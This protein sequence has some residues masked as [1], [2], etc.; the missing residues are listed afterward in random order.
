MVLLISASQVA[1]ITG[2]TGTWQLFMD[3]T[4]VFFIFVVLGMST[5]K[6]STELEHL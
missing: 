2:A 5:G 1:R 6:A 4:L 3:K